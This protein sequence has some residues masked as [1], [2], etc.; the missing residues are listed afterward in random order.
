LQEKSELILIVIPYYPYF[1]FVQAPFA[2][3]KEHQRLL[4]EAVTVPSAETEAIG[5]A[6]KEA[7]MVVSIGVNERGGARG[8]DLVCVP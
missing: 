2:M 7:N 1:S 5:Q 4:D 3:E 8:M 6:A